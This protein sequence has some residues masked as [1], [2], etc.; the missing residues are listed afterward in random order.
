MSP[1]SRR[2]RGVLT[3]A[4]LTGLAG[5]SATPAFAVDGLRPSGK[6]ATTGSGSAAGDFNGDGRD[7]VA[8]D[9]G[10]KIIFGTLTPVT[11]DLAQPLGSKGLTLKR[12]TGSSTL[13]PY[14]TAVG[15]LDHDGFDDLAVR[16]DDNPATFI[17]YGA[18][19]NADVELKAGPRVGVVTSPNAGEISRI[20]DWDGDGNDDF[21][22][23]RTYGTV[24]GG[25]STN[26]N[27]GVAVIRGGAR[28]TNLSALAAGP[29]VQPITAAANCQLMAQFLWL[30]YGCAF[31]WQNSSPVGDFDG[32]GKADLWVRTVD[33]SWIVH[34]R[35]S[36]AA[37]DALN[38]TDAI[39]IRGA[40]PNVTGTSVGASAL[41]DLNGDG[42]SDI[43][44]GGSNDPLQR[45]LFG[46]TGTA[47][48]PLAA[49]DITSDVDVIRPA[50]DVNGDGRDDV[51]LHRP[52]L[53]GEPRYLT[54]LASRGPQLAAGQGTPIPGLS[55]PAGAPIGDFDGDGKDD[56][57][58]ESLQ[59]VNWGAI[60]PGPGPGTD[61]T[62]PQL[63]LAVQGEADAGSDIDIYTT[64]NEAATVRFD[65]I[66]YTGTTSLGSF[67]KT[68]AAGPQTFRWTPTTTSGQP[69]G[70]GVYRLTAVARDAAGN[71]SAAVASDRFWIHEATVEQELVPP[72]SAGAAAWT[73]DGAGSQAQGVNGWRLTPA[74][75]NAVGL[76]ASANAINPTGFKYSFT[77]QASA[78]N[79]AA[80]GFTLAF[81]PESAPVKAGAGGGGLGIGGTGATVIAFDL[82]KGP[83]DPGAQFIGVSDST[84]TSGQLNY[85]QSV[86]AAHRMRG[87]A[88]K[89]DVVH[90][91]GLLTVSTNGKVR[92]TRTLALPAR[93]RVAFSA[94]TG[95]K[96][97][98][99]HRVAGFTMSRP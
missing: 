10:G 45:V 63:S 60:S 64:L 16:L 54:D 94:S 32:D 34:G 26:V 57:L 61:L 71:E 29:R 12:V 27:Q 77:A 20:G 19:G 14:A 96:T 59:L 30:R 23:T 90:Q 70:A 89:V 33:R 87:T 46:R 53:T 81:L 58:A 38:P 4:L 69:L 99:E 24:Y 91:N 95:A 6:L 79:G 8:T 28:I 92:L 9:Q 42:K 84:M 31:R 25:A 76:V 41:G 80:E 35:A 55:G 78:G 65:V 72:F 39:D 40:T 67:S 93:A 17:V 62:P 47:A 2:A 15:D 74:R 50:G 85:Q 36:T 48:I 75:A 49:A 88:F 11:I 37:I 18:A 1:S 21:T 13:P 73:A 97:Y 52:D 22:I 83:T 3:A 44:V 86:L 7:D 82:N 66:E 5:L 51:A 43:V 68:I 56:L 98:Q